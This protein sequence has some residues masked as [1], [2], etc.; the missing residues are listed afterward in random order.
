MMAG[1]TTSHRDGAR[2]RPI[3]RPHM[4][5]STRQADC[6]MSWVVRD[7]MAVLAG[8]RPRFPAPD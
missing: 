3:R 7:V 6:N 8:E 2:A 5:A 1:P 4:A